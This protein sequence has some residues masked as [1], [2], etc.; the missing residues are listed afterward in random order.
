M[1]WFNYTVYQNYFHYVETSEGV[2]RLS[3]H[4]HFLNLDNKPHVPEEINKLF[5][6]TPDAW[7]GE[8]TGLN[9]TKYICEKVGFIHDKLQR[10]IFPSVF[11][12]EKFTPA[13][14][15]TGYYKLLKTNNL[16][17]E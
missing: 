2:F 15:M 14:I 17:I 9:R 11:S 5:G 8:D 3:N 16:S 4:D 7:G 1:K 12:N 6:V 10:G 13:D